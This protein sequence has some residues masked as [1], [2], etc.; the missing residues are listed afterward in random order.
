MSESQAGRP[1]DRITPWELVFGAPG[2]D[3]SRFELLRDQAE[4]AAAHSPASLL[5][6]PAAGELLRELGGEAAG[7]PARGAPQGEHAPPPGRARAGAAD[8]PP[9]HAPATPPDTTPAAPP[10]HAPATPPDATPAAPPE[11]TPSRQQDVIAQVGAVLFHGYRFWRHGRQLFTIAATALEPRLA[12]PA[13]GWQF[14]AAAPAGYVQ[15]PHHLFWASVAEGA[16]PEPVDGFFWSAPDERERVAGDATMHRLDLLLVLGLR[17]ARPGLSLVEVTAE[18]ALQLER[19][20]DIAA[21]PDG[22]DFANVLPGGELQGYRALTTRAEALKLAMICFRLMDER[23]APEPDD[24][25]D[26]D[27]VVRRSRIDG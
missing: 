22:E 26:G 21:R 14:R 4:V 1:A 19:W 5:L 9:D 3:T 20:I 11:A 18:P 12:A 25:G 27:T 10:D 6:L 8:V 13:G 2:F 16:V 7:P 23:G 17:P 24:N 15:L